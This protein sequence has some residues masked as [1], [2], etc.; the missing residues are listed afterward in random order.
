MSV[1]SAFLVVVVEMVGQIIKAVVKRVVEMSS[2]VLVFDVR[3][4]TAALL[5]RSFSVVWHPL[6]A[7]CPALEVR[8]SD[9]VH[10]I[11]PVRWHGGCGLSIC[12]RKL[13][14][15]ATVSTSNLEIEKL[16][17]RIGSNA[18]SGYSNAQ[19]AEGAAEIGS[20]LVAKRGADLR[21]W[22][23]FFL[24]SELVPREQ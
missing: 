19:I 11:V 14:D 5:T 10:E 17:A 9:L 7:A 3:G 22:K 12:P 6:L 13:N 18:R 24:H 23:H 16:C 1:L 4:S 21:A 20:E 15:P 8:E 2:T